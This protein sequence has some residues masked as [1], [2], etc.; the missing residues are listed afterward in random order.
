MTVILCLLCDYATTISLFYYIR[1]SLSC[2]FTILLYYCNYNYYVY[3]YICM[4]IYMCVCMY[5]C[6]YVYI[7]MCMYIYIIH[8]DIATTIV[9]NGD[10]QGR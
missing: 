3:I 2:G 8:V 5:M 6:V 10:Q 7:Y 9:P 4:Y 1:V